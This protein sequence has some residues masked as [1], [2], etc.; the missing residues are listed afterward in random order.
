[1]KIFKYSF[2]AVL[3]VINI[4]CVF[5]Q[6]LIISQEEKDEIISYLDSVDYRGAL[7][8]ITEYKISEA[9]EKIEQVYWN[10]KFD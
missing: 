5:S 4:E 9:R 8:T 7:N 10:S 1:M 6:Q 2:I 3:F